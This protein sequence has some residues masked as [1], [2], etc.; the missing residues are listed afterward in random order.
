MV[1]DFNKMKKNAVCSNCMKTQE[2][3]YK[4]FIGEDGRIFRDFS[5]SCKGIPTQYISKKLQQVLT[6]EELVDAETI[7]DPVAW[8]QKYAIKTDGE[9]WVARWYQAEMLRC[10]A[11]RKV[12]RC[13][14]RIGKTDSISID[15]LYNCFTKS[16]TRALIVAP[17]KAQTEEI[18][19]RIRDFARMNPELANAIKRDVSSPFYEITFYN[20]SRV[21]GF[22]SGTKSGAEG[23]AI[24]GQDADRIYL[25]EA[26]YLMSGDL[27]SIIAILNTHPDVTLWASSTPTGKRQHFYKWCTDTP[28][29]R[30]FYFSS[31]VLP[32]WDTVK[33]DFLLE[34][35]GRPNDWTH[36]ILAEFGEQTVGVFQ[37][38]F[39]DRATT[40]YH[41]HEMQ[42]N[43]D[44]TYAMGVDWNNDVGTEIVVSGYDNHGG[45]WVV[46]AINIP[47]QEWT[48]IK[49]MEA[50]IAMN[51]KWRPAFLY[52]DEGFGNTNIE[53]LQ[54][55]G[56]DLIATNPSDPGVALRDRLV[57]YD[58]GSKL[59]VH[60]PVTKMPIK[61]DAKPFMVENAVRRFEE[62]RIK[63]S[64]FDS[65]LIRQLENYIIDHRTPA[66]RP[67][68][69]CLDKKLGDHRL[70]AFML[71]MV[72]FKLEMS[73]F[74][75]PVYD[76]HIA[77]S[78]GF[79][80]T[81][82]E[83]NRKERAVKR[84]Q[85]TPEERFDL[86]KLSYSSIPGNTSQYRFGPDRICSQEAW[87]TDREEEFQQKYKMR[88]MKKRS[89]RR[90]MRPERKNID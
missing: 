46:D 66:G 79:S 39:I 27:S 85:R 1:R 29:Y 82:G 62:S 88:Q 20:G 90:R 23:V 37:N 80:S 18:I 43:I 87:A 89:I 70:D 19:G 47:K 6:E 24:R 76:S 54:K 14:R 26:D 45:F 78:P 68:Y 17:Y 52:M 61:K 2:A 21:R 44:W 25:D 58:F 11:T 4:D 40:E 3:K 51:E 57:R 42:H 7:L 86:A 67:T 30:E 71:S 10:N 38:A 16:N 60:D 65:V 36:E 13:G 35:A 74:G 9:P 12:T 75:E 64:A 33:D 72:A 22:S 41:Y 8:A 32:H 50:V 31:T 53:L 83:E 56:H 28:T 69:G 55:Y 34:Y 49:G 81:V 77:I 48:Q 73:D 84:L 59:E 5:V 63:I 15:I